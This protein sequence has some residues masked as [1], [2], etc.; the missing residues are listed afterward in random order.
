MFEVLERDVP[1]QL[2]LC[3]S[4]HT[5]IDG[6]SDWIESTFGRFYGIAS[7]LGAETGRVFVI[8]HG[9]VNETDNGPVEICL[10]ILSEVDLAGQPTRVEPAHREA[11]TKITKSQVD[12]PQ[13][14]GAYEAVHTWV[15]ANA[16]MTGSPREVYVDG[17][18]DLQP[19]DYGCDIAFP[20]TSALQ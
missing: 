18:A 12:F 16:T 4:K 5:T 1:E 2:V 15:E 19:D 14:L 8:F 13:I 20:I 10:P 6:L 3:E 17:F 7:S 9:Q 11:Y